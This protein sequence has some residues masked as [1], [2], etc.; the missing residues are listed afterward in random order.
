MNANELLK[1][2]TLIN[3]VLFV[4]DEPNVISSLRRGL[5]GE[6]Y[7]KFF[8]VSAKEALQIMAENDIHVLVTDMRMPIMSGLELLKI[9]AE[10]YPSTVRIVLSGYAQ[11]PQVLA[12]INQVNVFRFVPKPWNMEEEFIP[13]IRDAIAYYNMTQ[14]YQNFKAALEK[15]NLAYQKTIREAEAKYQQF[16]LDWTAFDAFKHEVWQYGFNQLS[17]GKHV[18][19][20]AAE[21]S[22]LLAQL[23]A[24]LH[25]MSSAF[26]LEPTVFNPDQ[27][28]TTLTLIAKSHVAIAEE[29]G[30]RQFQILHDNN[31]LKLLGRYKLYTVLQK[32]ILSLLVRHKPLESLKVSQIYDPQTKAVL[33]QYDFPAA[34]LAEGRWDLPIIIFTLTEAHKLLPG[35]FFIQKEN[36]RL[37]ANSICTCEAQP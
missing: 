8:A 28:R 20:K 7:Q 30:E 25:E 21:S 32:A 36:A 1:N 24:L 15:Q 17:Q 29:T 4:D 16:K 35:K 18:E 26:P 3:N 10:K 27:L 6:T 12:T 13:M 22:F 9:V 31:H 2:D 19:L 37:I 5:V 23:D 14:E 34:L 11:L 33:I